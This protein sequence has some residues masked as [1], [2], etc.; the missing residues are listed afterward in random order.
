MFKGL[1]L[2]VEA[3]YFPNPLVALPRFDNT[4]FC[5]M[6]KVFK[7]L[8]LTVAVVTDDTLYPRRKEFLQADVLYITAMQ[9]VFTYLHD[10]TA[11]FAHAVVSNV[12]SH[13]EQHHTCTT[14]LPSS[15]IQ[16]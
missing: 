16:W 11:K 7:F 10:N 12:Q 5:R 13:P 6:G 8:G 9:L 14:T 3:L 15:S 4:L 2:N 1:R